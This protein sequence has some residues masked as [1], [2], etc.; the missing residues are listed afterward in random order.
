[1]PQAQAHRTAPVT[2]GDVERYINA[3][4]FYVPTREEQLAF[5]I[6]RLRI[7]GIH[8]SVG[9]SVQEGDVIASLYRP[10]IISQYTAATQREDILLLNISQAERRQN[11]ARAQA[12]R[13]GDPFTASNEVANLQQEHEILALELD[14]LRRE[15]DQLS[16]RASM[17]GNIVQVMDFTEGMMSDSTRVVATVSDQTYSVFEVRSPDATGYM[18]IGD[19]FTLMINQAPHDA[20]VVDPY[21][22]GIEREHLQGNEVFLALLDEETIVPAN[23]TSTVRVVANIAADVIMVPLRGVQIVGERTFVYTL[24]EYGL[25]T[26]RDVEAGLRGNTFIEI[27][28]G[29]DVGELVVID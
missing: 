18:N 23:P 29:L 11:Q 12:R 17:D 7:A 21:E 22:L 15:I 1:M 3:W 5:E 19:F 27:I 4:A 14:F 6:P 8:V 9:D 28:S 26:I 13:F 25:R 20:I 16:L 2:R 24:N 10:G